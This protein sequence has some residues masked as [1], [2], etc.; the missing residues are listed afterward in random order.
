MKKLE[1][2]KLRSKIEEIF[3]NRFQNNATVATDDV[4][5]LFRSYVRELLPEKG[6]ENTS[7]ATGIMATGWNAC[8][9]EITKRLDAQEV[10]AK[11]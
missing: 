3:W 4:V 1:E 2:Q 7:N 9:D 5:T 6:Q 8:L 11:E 10:S